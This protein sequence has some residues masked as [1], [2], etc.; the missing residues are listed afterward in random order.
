[1][2]LQ[3]PNPT[4]LSSPLFAAAVLT[5]RA[6]DGGRDGLPGILGADAPDRYAGAA[7]NVTR[8]PNRAAC[9]WAC[10]IEPVAERAADA[11]VRARADPATHGGPT[12]SAGLE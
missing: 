5:G 11:T 9:G 4:H 3:S 8:A 6:L 10:R 12:F 1:M 7:R 2:Q